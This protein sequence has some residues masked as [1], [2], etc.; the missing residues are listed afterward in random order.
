M[1]AT[2]GVEYYAANSES[3]KMFIHDYETGAFKAGEY[4]EI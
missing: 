2:E 3:A 1:D 4:K